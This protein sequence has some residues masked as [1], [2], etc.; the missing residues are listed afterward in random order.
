MEK[1]RFYCE[2]VAKER[3]YKY[4]TQATADCV[5]EYNHS[6]RAVAMKNDVYYFTSAWNVAYANVNA[7]G[8][9]RLYEFSPRKDLTVDGDH[10]DL[11]TYLFGYEEGELDETDQKIRVALTEQ[12]CD[13][14]NGVD[15]EEWPKWPDYYLIDYNADVEMTGASV[16]YHPE[17]IAFW[18]ENIERDG[19]VRLDRP[20]EPWLKEIEDSVVFGGL[21]VSDRFDKALVIAIVTI[22]VCIAFLV[23]VLLLVFLSYM[24]RERKPETIVYT[25]RNSNN[26]PR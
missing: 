1:L 5:K 11:I 15:R 2:I 18:N 16:N 20:S 10:D 26:L 6:N 3:N 22:I 12:W 23:F 8:T 19:N 9:S 4:L 7:G 25:T 13:F 21:L 24:N 14:I 17:A